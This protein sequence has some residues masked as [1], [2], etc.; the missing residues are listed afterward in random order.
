M[1]PCA[2]GYRYRASFVLVASRLRDVGRRDDVEAYKHRMGLI[3]GHFVGA[4]RATR[5][6]VVVYQDR[7]HR[8]NDV[9]HQEAILGLIR[10]AELLALATVR[11]AEALLENLRRTFL[12]GLAETVL[13]LAVLLATRWTEPEHLGIES[14]V[15]HHTLVK[16]LGCCG[17]EPR[18]ASKS[19]PCRLMPSNMNT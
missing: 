2:D 9:A 12:T 18:N 10:S 13:V 8:R 1:K 5:E 4:F 16:H 19:Y 15:G 6:R 3:A 14:S 11:D 7:E 17:K